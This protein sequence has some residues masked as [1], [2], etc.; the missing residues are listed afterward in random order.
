[1]ESLQSQAQDTPPPTA[2]FSSEVS[3]EVVTVDV[4]VTDKKGK[5]IVGLDRGDFKVFEDGVEMEI[6]NFYAA[7]DRIAL[8]ASD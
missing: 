5:P 7:Q 1:M 8:P 3:V 6:T 2:R 4:V